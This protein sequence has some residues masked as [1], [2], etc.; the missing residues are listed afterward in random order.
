M[1]SYRRMRARGACYFITLCLADRRGADLFN[2]IDLLRDAEFTTRWRLIKGRF[3]AG[4]APGRGRSLSKRLKSEKGIWQRRFWEHM[5][6]DGRDYDAHIRYCWS[7]PV[8][9]GLVKRAAE[10]PHSSIHRDIRL[11]RVEPDWAGEE[12]EGEFG[13]P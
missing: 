4:C 10:W 11:G 5:I 1:S 13:E 12:F 2:R 7:N 6:R 9:H 3:A 8:R